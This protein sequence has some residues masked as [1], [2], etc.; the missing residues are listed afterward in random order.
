VQP[1]SGA[2]HPRVPT[3]EERALLRLLPVL[4]VTTL[5]RLAKLADMTMWMRQGPK[6]M[7]R[8]IRKLNGNN[9]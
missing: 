2:L 7:R 1:I 8:L 5:A 9:N 4:P 3:K 6:L